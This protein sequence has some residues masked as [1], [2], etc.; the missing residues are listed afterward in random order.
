M[1]RDGTERWGEMAGETKMGGGG[2]CLQASLSIPGP[3]CLV[4][5]GGEEALPVGSPVQLE[6]GVLVAFE[7]H[8][9]LALPPDVPEED[10]LIV[11][12]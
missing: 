5:G 12:P 1:G 8:E 11:G 4:R 6:D 10:K 3:D 7:H 2:V 9:V